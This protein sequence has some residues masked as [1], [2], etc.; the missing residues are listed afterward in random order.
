MKNYDVTVFVDRAGNLKVYN[1]TIESTSMG[2]V[3]ND[4]TIDNFIVINTP[5]GESEIKRTFIN[6]EYVVEI[7]VEEAKK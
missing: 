6:L 5:I 3:R 1:F 4:I 2:H 7:T